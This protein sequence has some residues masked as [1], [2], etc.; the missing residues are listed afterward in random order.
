M[1][2]VRVRRQPHLIAKGTTEAELVESRV[3]GQLVE[4]NRLREVRVEQ[5]ARPCHRGGPRATRTRG[6]WTRS[7]ELAKG[8]QRVAGCALKL[9]RRGVLAKQQ[10]M[11]RRQRCDARIVRRDRI[12]LRCGRGTIQRR[13][14]LIDRVRVEEH[15][16]KPPL[17][18]AGVLG[19]NLS[20]D[21]HVDRSR[22]ARPARAS[23]RPLGPAAEVQRSG[24][25]VC[26]AP[27]EMPVAPELPDGHAG[28]RSWAGEL[29][30]VA[31]A[32]CSRQIHSSRIA[33]GYASRSGVLVFGGARILAPRTPNPRRMPC[34]KCT[35]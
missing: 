16:L 12:F 9:G 29:N 26:N 1:G 17:A 20:R 10:A 6:G 5:L 35:A 34:L 28:K 14:C 33:R 4:C 21:L 24:V 7:R 3:R 31:P 18:A 25:A 32:L 27:E 19:K 30:P 11:Q 15:D 13:T 2:H 8:Q 22:T 23:K